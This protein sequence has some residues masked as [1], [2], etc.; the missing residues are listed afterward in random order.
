MP[1]EKETM[2]TKIAEEKPIQETEQAAPEFDDGTMDTFSPIEEEDELPTEEHGFPLPGS[3]PEESP[4][5]DKE[6]GDEPQ[7]P[8][9]EDY[10]DPD[11]D[12]DEDDFYPADETESIDNPEDKD[13]IEYTQFE[14]PRP[15]EN[16]MNPEEAGRGRTKEAE[17]REQKKE[18]KRRGNIFQSLFGRRRKPEPAQDPEE[19]PGKSRRTR[20]ARNEEDYDEP[21]QKEERRR[22]SPEE[23]REDS[24]GKSG[25]TPARGPFKMEDSPQKLL[26]FYQVMVS[27]AQ[28]PVETIVDGCTVT[29][30]RAD[31]DSP[32]AKMA[33]LDPNNFK[34][35]MEDV[36]VYINGLQVTEEGL[37]KFIENHKAAFVQACNEYFMAHEKEFNIPGVRK[38]TQTPDKAPAG[39]DDG[40]RTQTPPVR[41]KRPTLEKPGSAPQPENPEKPRQTAHP[42]IREEGHYTP[43]GKVHPQEPNRSSLGV[44]LDMANMRRANEEVQKSLSK[45]FASVEPG[46]RNRI[47]IEGPD[48]GHDFLELYKGKD[49][50]PDS[51]RLNGKLVKDANDRDLTN[52]ALL[53]PGCIKSGVN[54]DLEYQE[55]HGY[56]PKENK[57]PDKGGPE[58]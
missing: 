3:Q 2:Q 43:E 19:N 38:A 50:K 29:G 1:E 48:G 36:N 46:T 27:Q 30:V 13:T 16:W 35:N 54:A 56:H 11:I 4:E 42:G 57:K 22:R 17:E 37:C 9:E 39:K 20:N 28:N 40:Q 41:P 52:I 44:Q 14:E 47:Q 6:H 34:D 7:R 24:T 12:F 32:E 58:H 21:E 15:N 5:E 49:G 10:E 31:Q 23:S 53:H 33:R 8:Q 18:S 26:D 55:K 25:K 51:I 45:W